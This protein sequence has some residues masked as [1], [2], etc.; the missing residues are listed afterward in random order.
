MTGYV[1]DWCGCEWS[2]TSIHRCSARQNPW[3]L[4]VYVTG[5]KTTICYL[6]LHLFPWHGASH[7]VWAVR[8]LGWSY[9]S[10][11]LEWYW[12][13]KPLWS[14]H[15]FITSASF[16]LFWSRL[17][18]PISWY[19]LLVLLSCHFFLQI[20]TRVIATIGEMKCQHDSE[21]LMPTVMVIFCSYW[22]CK[23]L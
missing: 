10:T 14:V 12:L 4:K 9:S 7:K 11:L 21:P 8:Y 13:W 16:L 5:E 6:I 2:R 3:Q 22:S 17:L 18:I 1:W 19:Y 23:R 20:V 15:D